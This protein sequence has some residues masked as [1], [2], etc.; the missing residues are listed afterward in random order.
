MKPLR[1]DYEA[2]ECSGMESSFFIG[3]NYFSFSATL[4]FILGCSAFLKDEG[5]HMAR[6]FLMMVSRF[7][8]RFAPHWLLWAE[9][10]Q[11]ARSKRFAHRD[12]MDPHGF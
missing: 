6:L 7:W 8:S 10:L 1:A 11:R 2:S 9:E 3:L 12:P 5:I 4:F